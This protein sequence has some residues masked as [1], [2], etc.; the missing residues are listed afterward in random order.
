MLRDFYF[1]TTK[2]DCIE[3]VG[4]NILFNREIRFNFNL[5]LP[6]YIVFK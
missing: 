5:P 3:K 2:P 1:K 4:K 6:D